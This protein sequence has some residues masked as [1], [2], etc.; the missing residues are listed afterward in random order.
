MYLEG[1]VALITGGG[2]GIGAEIARR[3]IADG[4]KVCISGRRREML[5]EIA[6][7]LPGGS[8]TTCPGD[9]TVLDDVERMVDTTVKFGANGCY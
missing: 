8:I 6:N 7:T 1:K 2:A 5:D 3:Y 4:A 9:V